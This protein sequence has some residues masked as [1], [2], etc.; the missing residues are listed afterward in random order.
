MR[1]ENC[2]GCSWNFGKPTFPCPFCEDNDLYIDFPC[3]KSE[4]QKIQKLLIGIIS[5]TIY[6]LL[7]HAIDIDITEIINNASVQK[8]SINSD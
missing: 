8:E 3:H 4:E 2:N 6:Y 5:A 7:G 1:N